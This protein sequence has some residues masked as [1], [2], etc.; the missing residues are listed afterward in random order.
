MEECNYLVHEPCL[1]LLV[2]DAA[3]LQKE[4]PTQ[5]TY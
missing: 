5:H 4:R 3:H 1:I 2:L